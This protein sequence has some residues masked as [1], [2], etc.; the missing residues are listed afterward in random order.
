VVRIS[1]EDFA[2]QVS[3][4]RVMHASGVQEQLAAVAR[5]GEFFLGGLFEL[6]WKPSLGEE[7]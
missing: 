4:F 5:F 6:Y 1:V 7:S 2:R 3:T